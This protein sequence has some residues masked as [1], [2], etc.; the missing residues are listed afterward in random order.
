M[1]SV[2]VTVQDSHQCLYA[3]VDEDL[4]HAIIGSLS[5]DPETISELRAAS[6]R[7]V[8]PDLANRLFSDWAV[9]H[10]PPQD[11]EPFCVIDLPAPTVGHKLAARLGRRSLIHSVCRFPRSVGTLVPIPPE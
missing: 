10:Q 9:C 5:A 3:M 7:F 2:H 11:A 8:H 1:S 4:T 6:T